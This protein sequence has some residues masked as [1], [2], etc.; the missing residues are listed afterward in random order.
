[1]QEKKQI[2]RFPETIKKSAVV[3]HRGMAVP[4]VVRAALSSQVPE[5]HQTCQLPGEEG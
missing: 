5:S 4:G 1:M 2:I 3:G